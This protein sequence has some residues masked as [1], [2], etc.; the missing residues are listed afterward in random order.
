MYVQPTSKSK[1]LASEHSFI[2][3]KELFSLHLVWDQEGISTHG[4][5]SMCS[6]LHASSFLR[7][8]LLPTESWWG[9]GR[10]QQSGPPLPDKDQHLLFVVLLCSAGSLS[11]NPRASGCPHCAGQHLSQWNFWGLTS[12]LWLLTSELPSQQPPE[13]FTTSRK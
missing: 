6:V 10:S 5:E 2:F 9:E 7:E 1:S 8:P 12:L 4:V 11:K 3:F 13:P